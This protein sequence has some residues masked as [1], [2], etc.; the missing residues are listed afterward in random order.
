MRHTITR[1]VTHTI[2][3]TDDTEQFPL[4]TRGESSHVASIP[5]PGQNNSPAA[6][7]ETFIE[8][9]YH[10]PP[11]ASRSII[12]YCPPFTIIVDT[13]EPLHTAYGFRELHAD[14]KKDYRPLRVATERR[15]L[16][17]NRGDYSVKGMEP[18][19][20]DTALLTGHEDLG[21]IR[22]TISLERKSQ[23]DAASTILGW[24]AHRDN[25]EQELAILSG[26]TYAAVL[27]EC[28]EVELINSAPSY[29]VKSAA[30]NARTLRTSITAWRIAFPRVHWI[31]ADGGRSHAECICYRLLER[32]FE[33]YSR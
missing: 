11:G 31:F 29:G 17:L 24:G 16:G 3:F 33:E 15:C 21:R 25:F 2:D 14:A 8:P 32:F 6:P 7:R 30:E 10:I 9:G 26:L 13:R 12:P 19:G 20:T 5:S 27:I 23:E 4:L 1:S 28:G 22:P 18:S